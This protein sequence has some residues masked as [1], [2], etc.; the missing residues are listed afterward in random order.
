L[1]WCVV[2]TDGVLSSL[3]MREALN[4]NDGAWT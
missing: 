1:F 3:R 2:N 4:L